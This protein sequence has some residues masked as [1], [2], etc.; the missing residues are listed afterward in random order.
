MSTTTY[1]YAGVE[2]EQCIASFLSDRRP[3]Q[4]SCYW[5]WFGLL[6]VSVLYHSG[7]RS[8]EELPFPVA[9][10]PRWRRGVERA[11]PYG[12]VHV[13]RSTLSGAQTST[14]SFPGASSGCMVREYLQDKA[15]T[16]ALLKAESLAISVIND[17]LQRARA[18]VRRGRALLPS[19]R[20]LP[21]WLPPCVGADTGQLMPGGAAAA[22]AGRGTP[23]IA[24]LG[25]DL[26]GAPNL[27]ARRCGRGSVGCG[28]SAAT[29]TD[30]RP[31]ATALV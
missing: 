8:G 24:V 31:R 5:V 17:D 21:P 20:D 23:E 12:S 4:R 18:V 30:F 26:D 7:R 22:A 28:C 19:R 16:T 11:A 9:A 15:D 3:F 27:Q 10:G 1:P 6:P 25:V 13:S 14:A 2:V 29:A